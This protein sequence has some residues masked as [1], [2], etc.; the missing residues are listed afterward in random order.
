MLGREADICRK[1]AVAHKEITRVYFYG[2][3]VWGNPRLDSDLD[4]LVVAQPGSVMISNQEWT[5][6]LT[7]LFGLIVHLND[8]FTADS[9]VV[10]RIKSDGLLV[11]SRYETDTDFQFEDELDF[12]SDQN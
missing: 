4:I 7:P 1:W 3:R 9:E 2:S 11:F 8:Y 6:E 12:D 5:T 10:A